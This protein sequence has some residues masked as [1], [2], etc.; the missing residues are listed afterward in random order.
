MFESAREGKT[1][2]TAD[3]LA[4]LRKGNNRFIAS[5][6]LSESLSISRQHVYDSIAYLRRCGYNIEISRGDGYKLISSPDNLLPVEI[7]ANLAC[8]RFAERIFSYKT[9]GSTNT[10]AQNLARSGMPEGTLVIADT[11]TRGRGRLGRKWHSPP[12]KGLYFS[13]I[14]KPELPPEK[15][16]GLSLVA[17]LAIVRAINQ[18]TG[19]K[20]RTKWPNDVL[21]ESKKLAGI[22]VELTAE[23]GKIDYM[24]VGCG[25]NV[26][27]LRK[28]FPLN[29]QRK[30]TSL[31]II[32]KKE[33]SRVTLLQHVLRQ[34]EK[35]YDNYRGHG[36]KYLS[37]ELI[38]NSALIGKRITLI[39]GK[40]RIAGIAAGF[41]DSGHIVI[42][43]KKGLMSYP[44]GEVTLR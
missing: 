20:T 29:L 37:A 19:I 38:Q 14:L 1:G 10:V 2:P 16:A 26:N 31:K 17:G 13:L 39:T 18:V 4:Y 36:F 25:L 44:A 30:S 9:I 28:D 7:A 11:Q 6:E 12:G 5:H 15:M 8:R 24:I 27:H 41:D 33:Y 32:G 3:I 35:L 21:F 43:N 23:V 22:L 42:K 40:T 34:F